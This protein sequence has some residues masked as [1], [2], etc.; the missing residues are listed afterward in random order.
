[1]LV[2]DKQVF[3]GTDRG[4][5]PTAEGHIYAFDS[6]TGKAVWKYTA[7]TGVSTDLLRDGSQLIA[8][9]ANGEL[10]SLDLESGKP[11]WKKKITEPNSDRYLPSPALLGHVVFAATASSAVVAVRTTDGEVLWRRQLEPGYLQTVILGNELY[12][13][14]GAKY[15]YRLDQGQWGR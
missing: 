12:V 11:V 5:D 4:T 1:M 6:A 9:C 2:F 13:L 14:S 3:V 8:Y 10:L 15:L 7:G